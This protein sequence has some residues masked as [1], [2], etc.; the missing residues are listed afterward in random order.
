LIEAADFGASPL[1]R[2]L[3]ESKVLNRV[4]TVHGFGTHAHVRFNGIQSK[5]GVPDCQS[6]VRFAPA[7]R[8]SR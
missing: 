7:E 1:L 4:G 2:Q 6:D 3:S 5:A 8:I